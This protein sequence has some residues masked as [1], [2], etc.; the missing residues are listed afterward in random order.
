MSA[1]I[2]YFSIVIDEEFRADGIFSSLHDLIASNFQCIGLARFNEYVDRVGSET[3]LIKLALKL[4]TIISEI[5]RDYINIK[6]YDL[7]MLEAGYK[8]IDDMIA[9]ISAI[10]NSMSVIAG[11][12]PFAKK[13]RPVKVVNKG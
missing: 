6:K 10:T 5:R 9:D 4:N 11:I 2:E 12:V 1:I 7:A 13:V 8:N 3:E